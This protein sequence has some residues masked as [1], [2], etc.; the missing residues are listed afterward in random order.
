MYQIINNLLKA[1][2]QISF[3]INNRY[4]TGSAWFFYDTDD[5]L[6]N[7][8]LVTAAHCVME[9][10]NNIYYTASQIYFQNPLNNNWTSVDVNNIYI[11]G[12]SDVAIIQTNIDFTNSPQYCLKLADN[13]VYVGDTCCII[14]N[15]GG[16][17]EDSLCLGI[18]RDPHYCEPS[19]Y[20][21]TDS[22]LISAPGMGGNSG[23]PIINIQ[24][25]VIGIY[26]FGLTGG[27]ECFG[28]GSNKDVLKKTL[29]VLK[30]NQNN[31]TKR[32]LGLDWVI[33]SPFTIKDFYNQ[34]NFS[35]NGVYISEVSNDS[36][37]NGILSG[38]DLL[39]RCVLSNEETIEFGNK[40][41][42]KTPGVLIYFDSD[43]E[44]LIFYIKSGTTEINS[45]TISLNKT[46]NDVSILLDGPLQTGLR[47]RGLSKMLNRFEI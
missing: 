45:T 38:G 17:D 8:Y 25:K 16:I 20:Q 40:N 4:Y 10:T 30:S 13:D 29:N 23:G 43:I 21:I 9:I 15:P 35:T 2:C 22:I 11:D 46:Y 24:G 33:P 26:T 19:G 14:G 7:G 18:V 42:E 6:K 27:F 1:C 44:I 32:Y 36:P 34:T 37:F 31:K 28:G 39:L 5:D 47:S 41:S 12:I 3:S